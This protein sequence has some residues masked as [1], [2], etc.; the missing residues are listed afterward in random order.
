MRLQRAKFLTVQV[1]SSAQTGTCRIVSHWDTALK[2]VNGRSAF[3]FWEEN[4]EAQYGPPHT[5]NTQ[6]VWN[7]GIVRVVATATVS[8]D[9]IDL[10]EMT[11]D[12]ESVADP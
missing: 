9:T 11:P 5:R 1:R 3:A 12:L 10:D 6:V 4:S 7:R 8:N 2:V